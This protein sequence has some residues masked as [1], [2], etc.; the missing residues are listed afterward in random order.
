MG[1]SV[2]WPSTVISNIGV[3]TGIVCGN[4]Y[5]VKAKPNPKLSYV[6]LGEIKNDHSEDLGVIAGS[7][8]PQLM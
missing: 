5:T 4:L 7:L 6:E 1:S 2:A 3:P 8:R